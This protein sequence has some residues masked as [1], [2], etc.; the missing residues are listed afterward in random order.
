EGLRELN[1]MFAFVFF[2]RQEHRIILSK[3]IYGIKPMYYYNDDNYF[4]ASSEI[5]G[6]LASGLVAK[7]FN[8]SQVQHYLQLGFVQRPFTFYKNIYE[9]NEGS[10]LQFDQ[11]SFKVKKFGTSPS[12][13]YADL[14]SETLVSKLNGFIDKSIS[15]YLVSDV[16]VGLYLGS[17]MS[18]A[19]LLDKIARI[20]SK[21]IPVFSFEGKHADKHNSAYEL[22]KKYKFDHIKIT[23]ETLNKDSFEAFL[24]AVDQPIGE[25]AYFHSYHLSNQ[26]HPYVKV[27][28]LGNGSNEL[29]GN[30]SRH[31]AYYNYLKRLLHNNLKISLFKTTHQLLPAQ[32]NNSIKKIFKN[33]NKYIDLIDK[34]P[35]QTYL[36]FCSSEVFLEKSEGVSSDEFLSEKHEDMSYYLKAAFRFDQSKILTSSVLPIIDK[37]TMRNSIEARLPFLDVEVKNFM[38]SLDPKLLFKHG[39]NWILKKLVEYTEID[40]KSVFDTISSKQAD[41]I[42]ISEP[43]L[44]EIHTTINNSKHGIYEWISPLQKASIH[45]Y[46]NAATITT[47]NDRWRLFLLMKWYDKEF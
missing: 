46:L 30:Y 22:I 41:L 13:E 37:T 45:K 19:L 4:I 9:L 11:H 27:A 24:S 29:F 34:D 33:W 42:D 40:P 31:I 32:G 7:Q 35:I 39:H 3:D 1:G 17:G 16:P 25:Y 47:F 14:N 10:Y 18:S 12:I 36:N 15:K 2:D 21:S 6:I 26:M 23:P 28:I 8:A 20:G 43:F 38:D 5:K 44:A